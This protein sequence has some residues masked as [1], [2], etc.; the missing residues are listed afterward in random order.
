M[1][2]GRVVDSYVLPD[3]LIDDP[4]W[5]AWSAAHLAR[6]FDRGPVV[7]N[8]LIHAELSMGF[9]R[10]E[11]LDDALPDRIVWEDLPWQAGFLAGRCVLEYRRRGGRRSRFPT[12][13]SRHMRRSPVATC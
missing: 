4:L 6:A 12:S 9:D 5:S 11:D 13:P 3:V 2:S 10:I 8:P 1:S 7:I